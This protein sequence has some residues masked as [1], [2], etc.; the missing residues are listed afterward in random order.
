MKLVYT[1]GCMC[2]D[3]EIDGKSISKYT[4][5]Q[6]K[7]IMKHLVDITN[8]IDTMIVDFVND[9]GEP[10]FIRHCNDCGDDIYEYTLEV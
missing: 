8:N 10:K 2:Y 9:N 7:E 1:E 3:L 5:E 4:I 6:K